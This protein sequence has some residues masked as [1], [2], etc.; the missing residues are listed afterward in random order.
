MPAQA[1]QAPFLAPQ[2][3]YGSA[4]SKIKLALKRGESTFS[5]RTL[6]SSD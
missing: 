5:V 3:T 2:K 6:T 1:P 4:Q